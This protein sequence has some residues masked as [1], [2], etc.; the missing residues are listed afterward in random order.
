[1]I[2]LDVPKTRR[3][4]KERGWTLTWFAKQCGISRC[5]LGHLFIGMRNPSRKTL[6]AFAKQLRVAQKELI[7]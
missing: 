4:I 3:M 1:M 6:K 7:K 2:S 5:Y